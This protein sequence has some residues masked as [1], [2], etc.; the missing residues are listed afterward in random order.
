MTLLDDNFY[1]NPISADNVKIYNCYTTAKIKEN[2]IFNVE[3]KY[4]N[5][6]LI[7]IGK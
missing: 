4:E 1:T 3:E 5:M 6:L 7:Y 2:I